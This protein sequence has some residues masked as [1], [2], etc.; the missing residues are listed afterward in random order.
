MDHRPWLVTVVT[1]LLENANEEDCGTKDALI[2][3]VVSGLLDYVEEDADV[4]E[5]DQSSG[6]EDLET[7]ERP[8]KR[9]RSLGSFE[10]GD[11]AISTPSLQDKCTSSTKTQPW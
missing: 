10:L 6:S 4:W 7:S 8:T 3:W 5:C 2:D 1:N 9:A 11:R